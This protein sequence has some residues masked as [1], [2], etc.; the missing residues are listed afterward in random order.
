MLTLPTTTRGTARPQR[1]LGVKIHHIYYWAE[2]FLDPELERT[3][4]PVRFD[5]FDAGIAY[6]FVKGR[7]VRCISEHYAR[8]TGR[9]EREIQLA[10]AEL[11]RRN[12][13][14]GQQLPLTARKLADFLV[15]VEAEEVL[16]EQRLRDAALREVLVRHQPDGGAPSGEA[17]GVPDERVA[18]G[19][20]SDPWGVSMFRLSGLPD[21][22][23]GFGGDQ[24]IPLLSEPR[25]PIGARVVE[26]VL[27]TPEV[28]DPIGCRPLSTACF[29]P[30]VLAEPQPQFHLEPVGQT[31]DPHHPAHGPLAGQPCSRLPQAP[32]VVPV[33]E[34]L[35]DRHAGRILRHGCRHRLGRGEQDPG[36]GIA[37]RPD[38][39]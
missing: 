25:C 2:A 13:R 38:A 21:G 22:N 17:I 30:L 35:L 37:L 33:A 12:Q 18:P 1:R 10:S 6:A 23:V 24:L 16:L 19:A 11:R 8:F 36:L 4:L 20:G 29:A 34:G 26:E 7:W 28:A 39:R 15:S 5:P 9:S 3:R 32:A 31:D 27:G 14:H